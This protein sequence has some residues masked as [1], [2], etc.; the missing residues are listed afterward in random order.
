MSFLSTEQH[1]SLKGKKNPGSS[2]SRA[3]SVSVSAPVYVCFCLCVC[4]FVSVCIVTIES[5]F[6]GLFPDEHRNRSCKAEISICTLEPVYVGLRL[7]TVAFLYTLL[8]AHKHTTEYTQDE[9]QCLQSM[10]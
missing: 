6:A 4:V 10:H 1:C 2:S 9:H 7:C 5:A 3:F 8:D